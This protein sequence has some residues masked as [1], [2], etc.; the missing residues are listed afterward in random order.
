MDNQNIP[1]ELLDLMAIKTYQELS[2]QEKEL[3]DQSIGKDTYDDNYQVIQA[4]VTEDKKLEDKIEIVSSVFEKK[5]SILHQ[6][7]Y[8]R[9]P[10]YQVAAILVVLIGSVFLWM[11]NTSVTNQIPGETQEV[12]QNGKSLS[13]D[14][15]PDDL[16]FN[17]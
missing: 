5:K 12:V 1:E 10:L 6:V 9:I 8:Y 15:Y 14:H 11:I 17:L 13:K 3:V 2:K 16:V 4:F 7:L